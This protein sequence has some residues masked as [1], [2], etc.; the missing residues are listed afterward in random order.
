MAPRAQGVTDGIEDESDVQI[1]WRPD[2]VYRATLVIAA[3]EQNS[4]LRLERSGVVLS[5]HPVKARLTPNRKME[6]T[7]EYVDGEVH[8]AIDGEP[9]LSTPIRDGRAIDD[10]Q[11]SA[12]GSAQQLRLSA[13]GHPVVFADLRLDRDLYYENSFSNPRFQR[14]GVEIPD[15]HYFMLGDNT[16]SSS[17][18]RKWQLIVQRLKDGTV[19]RHDRRDENTHWPVTYEEDGVTW[20]RA[21]DEYGV[22]RRW[23]EEDEDPDHRMA[24]NEDAPFVPRD[25]IVGRAF[26]V[27]WPVTPDF[28]GRLHFTH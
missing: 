20:K 22:M 11:S 24:P 23:R 21:A 14:E 25:L 26:L 13:I 15:D 9:V 2:P 8:A 27:F 4:H 7:L 19:I 17:D 10:T 28:P 1:S 6:L 12:S 3:K 5:S 18:S 16:L